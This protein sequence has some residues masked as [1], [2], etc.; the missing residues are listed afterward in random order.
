MKNLIDLDSIKDNRSRLLD[1]SIHCR[2]K[3]TTGTCNLIH[4]FCV[5]PTIMV[6]KLTIRK[7][8]RSF[9]YTN[10]SIQATDLAEYN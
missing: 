5:K 7:N 9:F 3:I 10:R 1:H 6:I 4:G 2:A 8:T